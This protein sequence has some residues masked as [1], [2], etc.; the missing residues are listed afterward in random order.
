MHEVRGWDVDSKSWPGVP[1]T[2]WATSCPNTEW[3]VPLSN[4]GKRG[5]L[6]SPPLNANAAN[7]PWPARQGFWHVFWFR[8]LGKYILARKKGLASLP[9]G[10]V[11]ERATSGGAESGH[12]STAGSGALHC[13]VATM[14]SDWMTQHT[15]LDAAPALPF[16]RE[17]VSS[18]LVVCPTRIERQNQHCT[19]HCPFSAAKRPFIQV[20]LDLRCYLVTIAVVASGGRVPD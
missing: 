20:E 18:G 14:L 13:A 8:F 11:G 19:A 5:G 10:D 15:T 16:F 9:R 2:R 17:R 12:A 6:D 7:S 3:R 1:G 4:P